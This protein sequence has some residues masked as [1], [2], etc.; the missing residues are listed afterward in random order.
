MLLHPN[1]EVSGLADVEAG[2]FERQ[3]VNVSVSKR[4]VGMGDRRA[5][6]VVIFVGRRGGGIRCVCAAGVAHELHALAGVPDI[7]EDESV[8]IK[9]PVAL[10]ALSQSPC[11]PFEP[12]GIAQWFVVGSCCLTI[13]SSTWL[14]IVSHAAYST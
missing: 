8:I 6:E 14:F 10:G 13:P 3:D 7:S 5:W 1:V 11:I 4:N 9:E 12:V 2:I